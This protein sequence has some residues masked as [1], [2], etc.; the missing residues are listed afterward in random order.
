MR[1]LGV[2]DEPFLLET[3]DDNSRIDTG[4]CGKAA[5]G[6]LAEIPHRDKSGKIHDGQQ[7]ICGKLVG[8]LFCF[9]VGSVRLF[10]MSGKNMS[11]FMEQAEPE[12][13]GIPAANRKPHDNPSLSLI[14]ISEPT[15]PY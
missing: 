4:F 1:V 9:T 10:D 7:N 5:D 14:H 6:I 13:V 2:G 15:R 12:T 3:A 11:Q 8:L